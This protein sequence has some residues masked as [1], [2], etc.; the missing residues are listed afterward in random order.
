[1]L[2]LAA[3]LPDIVTANA[4]SDRFRL[5]NVDRTRLE[6]VLGAKDKIV[7]YLSIK[8][9]RKLLYR[10]GPKTFKD[11]AT[12]R[13]AE[14]PKDSNAVQWRALLAV[15]D[16]WDR[17]EFPLTGREVMNAGV[18]EGPLVGRILAEVEDW[19]IDSDFTED[20]FSLAERLKAVVQA[21]AY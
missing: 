19:W 2:R 6:D 7:S 4:V 12:L 17:P 11:R 3:L 8:E 1:M 5:S 9:V 21:T 10:L 15:A 14:D 18:P 16:A 13:W 20:E